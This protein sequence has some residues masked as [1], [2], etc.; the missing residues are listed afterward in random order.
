[1]GPRVTFVYFSKPVLASVCCGRVIAT[2]RSRVMPARGI[3]TQ[4]SRERET[5]SE[6]L[7]RVRLNQP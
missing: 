5:H 3:T 1:M 6:I 2:P 7:R 4:R